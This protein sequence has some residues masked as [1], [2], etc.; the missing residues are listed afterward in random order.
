MP[1]STVPGETSSPTQPFPSRP[2]PFE[3]QGMSKGDLPHQASLWPH[4]SSRSDDRGAALDGAARRGPPPPPGVQDLG[5]PPLGW[6]FRTHTLL[7]KTLLFGAQEGLTSGVQPSRRGFA[8]EF[9]LAS[10]DPKLRAFDKGTGALA[11]EIA[12]PAN[13]NGAPMTYMAGGRP[14]LVV[15]V[16]GANVPAELV[17]LRLP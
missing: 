6:P 14:Y 11:A 2:A 12:L 15:A 13:A 3:R 16:G 9:T 5:L 17:A 4:D 7:T 10:R 1:Q 8:D